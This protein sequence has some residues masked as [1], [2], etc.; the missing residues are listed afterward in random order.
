MVV[1]RENWQALKFMDPVDRS[2][3]ERVN[4]SEDAF[5]HQCHQIIER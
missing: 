1:R 2:Y 5:P 4:N 3:S